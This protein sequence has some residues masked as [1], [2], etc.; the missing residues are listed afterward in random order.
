MANPKSTKIALI[1]KEACEYARSQILEGSTQLENN[2]Y[3]PEKKRSLLYAM[4]HVRAISRDEFR[5]I[6]KNDF[7]PG[8]NRA[9][10][11]FEIQISNCKKF[12]LGCC[13]ELAQMALHYIAK[14]HPQINAEQFRIAG[15]NHTFLVIGRDPK[16][17]PSHPEA[18]N[19]ETYICDPWLNKIYPANAYLTEL[20]NYWQDDK[21]NNCIEDFNPQKHAIV[22]NDWMGGL[23][24]NLIVQSVT[25]ANTILLRTFSC[26]N[27]RYLLAYEDFISTLEKSGGRIKLRYGE[28]DPKYK[29]LVNKI[30]VIKGGIKELRETYKQY[31]HDQ[32]Q[33][34]Q[35]AYKFH[36]NVVERHLSKQL[37]HDERFFQK[38]L[39]DL[40]QLKSLTKEER[41]ILK[42]YRDKSL[43]SMIMEF[44][45]IASRSLR[46]YV[47]AENTVETQLHRV[48]RKL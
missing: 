33:M 8:V 37:G 23:N 22:L 4:S 28:N 18:W 10:L 35:N 2:L 14:E 40:K 20:K 46:D 13:G 43:L 39:K 48:N 6:V 44:L 24:T 31:Y 1:A 12:S 19:D 45:H 30:A 41:D 32:F 3:S 15:G 38:K 11:D 5:H 42:N 21:N 27:E 26:L 17:D 25:R 29:V 9:F 34:N 36:T 47:S 16:S 7:F